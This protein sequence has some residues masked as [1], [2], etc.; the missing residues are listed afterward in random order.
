MHS[1]AIFADKFQTFGHSLATHFL[2][3][4]ENEGQS[5]L[6][7]GSV[8]AVGGHFHGVPVKG[9]LFR[10]VKVCTFYLKRILKI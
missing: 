3:A 2:I 6:C 10:Q 4:E 9:K 7:A 5:R 8:S 1:F